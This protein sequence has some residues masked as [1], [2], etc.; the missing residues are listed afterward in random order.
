MKKIY[1]LFAGLALLPSVTGCFSLEKE[2]EVV[3]STSTVFRT[4]GEMEK[5]LNNFYNNAFRGHP[6]TVNG[7]GIAF[8]DV[9]SDNMVY[10]SVDTRL[11]GAL[12]VSN[13]AELTAYDWIRTV[14]FL[15][16]NL[17]HYTGSTEDAAYK[18]CV[19]EAYYFR[20]WYYYGLL[21]DYGGV[22]WIDKVMDPD[23]EQLQLPR[24]S[25]TFIADKILADLDMAIENL[26]TQS[27]SASMRVHK[28]VARILKSEVALFEGTWEK[29]HKLK[30][31]A[32]YDPEV[33]DDK[34]D[35]YLQQAVDAVAPIIDGAEAGRWRIYSTGNTLDDYRSLFVTYD[36]SSNPEVLWWKKYDIADN[37][38]HSVT[39][40]QNLGGG[41]K[42]ITASLVD[43]Y[44]TI[45][46]KPYSKE[47]RI[48]AKKVYGTELQPTVRDPRLSQTVCIPG[49]QLRPNT[50]GDEEP[51]N[52][53]IF[54]YPLL[55]GDPS[56]AYH[57]NATGYALLKHVE[58]DPADLSTIEGEYKSQAP[59]IQ[60]RY[61]EALLN[62]AEALAELDGPGNAERIKAALK[63]LRDR[64]GMP[65]VDFDREFN[66]DSDYPMMNVAGGDDK[67]I[68]AVRRERR[69]EL[70]CEGK[71]MYDIFRWAAADVLI[72]GYTPS[73]AVF[74][75]SDLEG[76]EFYGDA[77]RYDQPA[78]NNLFLTEADENGFRYI[79][80]YGNLPNGYQFKVDRDYLLPIRDGMI[81][82]TNN[83]WVQNPGW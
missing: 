27:S 55:Q 37:I 15:L 23:L 38:G 35:D 7:T 46:G 1:I 8:G 22:T 29:Y 75:G 2:P 44:L 21:K 14:N 60:F 59:A 61:A 24:D 4:T 72:K 78:D 74:T 41:Q 77:L 17:D 73:G 76:N 16:N 63:P 49:Q 5:Y 31:D 53:F 51:S 58:I 64:V 48:E 11:N 32:F 19:G 81:T 83:L 65:E 45:D 67:Y 40:F 34:I 68:Q 12:S 57:S 54:T 69:V 47:E 36:L 39:R 33:T 42:G 43:D 9:Q 70:A 18:Q 52:A 20:A 56:G 28:D 80:P 82:L 6:S 79:I 26:Q 10:S 13:G 3:I 62:F 71:R 25:R 50:A 30:G 66:S